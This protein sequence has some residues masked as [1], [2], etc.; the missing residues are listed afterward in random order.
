MQ[1]FYTPRSHFSR[2]VRMLLGGLDLRADLVDAGNVAESNPQLFGANPLMK[3]PTLVDGDCTILDSDHIAQYL[4]RTYD[5]TDRFRVGTT[6]VDELNTRAVMNG[7]M[8]TEVEL[9]LAARTG[10]DTHAHR[11][12][13]KMRSAIVAGLGWLEQRGK[14]FPMEPTY[15]GFHLA[16]MWDHLELY[17]VCDLDFPNLRAAATRWNALPYIA[18]TKPV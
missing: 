7:I 6:D 18:A 11:R 8:A 14:V 3:V 10:L 12:F 17:G 9:I 5:P 4:V 15:L 2:K 16:A 1:L 13:D